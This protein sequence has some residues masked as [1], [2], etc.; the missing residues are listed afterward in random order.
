MS[1]P[2]YQDDYVTLWHGDAR[3]IVPA[4]GRFDLLLTDPPYG[5][6]DRWSGGGTWQFHKGIYADAKKWDRDPVDDKTMCKLL[7]GSTH[8]I[9]W[10]YNYLTMPPSRGCLAWVKKELMD[11]VADFEL[12]WTSFDFPAKLFSE[13]RNPDGRR[14]HPTQKPL[15][16]MLWC[17]QRADRENGSPVQVV[18]DPF[19]GSGTTGRAAKDLQRQCVLIEREEQYCEMA[20]HRMA[21]EVLPLEFA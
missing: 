10:G 6:G 18:F 19:A 4:L 11:T 7:A 14:Q 5:L 15:S 17:I 2:Y 16:L 1:T 20:A 13:R 3:E 8:A 21:Q 12:A 9:V